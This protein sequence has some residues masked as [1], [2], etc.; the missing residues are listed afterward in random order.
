MKKTHSLNDLEI[1]KKN[2][3]LNE[4]IDLMGEFH[5]LAQELNRVHGNMNIAKQQNANIPSA[6]EDAMYALEH[7]L[8][9]Y[10]LGPDNDKT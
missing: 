6:L 9:R 5:T 4:G 1:I 8:D 7:E 10:T 2:A 3:G